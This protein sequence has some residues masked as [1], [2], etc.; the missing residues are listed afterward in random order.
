VQDKTS[1]M[2]LEA[3]HADLIRVRQLKK[4]II[5][6]KHQL[7]RCR[8]EQDMTKR[9]NDKRHTT[10][11]DNAFTSQHKTKQVTNQGQTRDNTSTA[12]PSH[13]CPLTSSHRKMSDFT[14]RLEQRT[15]VRLGT[16]PWN[17]HQTQAT[18][19]QHLSDKLP[20]PWLIE[21]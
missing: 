2:F 7:R 12:A 4:S 3:A 21:T 11:R 20:E 14:K 19:P 5:I 16:I 13:T 15:N 17:L 8:T 6:V 18:R 1:L 9:D 10:R